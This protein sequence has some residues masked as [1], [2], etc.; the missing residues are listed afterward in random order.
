MVDLP[1][2]V[3]STIENDRSGFTAAVLLSNN[4]RTVRKIRELLPT[5]LRMVTLTSSS[6][7][8]ENLKESNIDVEL[9]E[10]SL[11]SQGLSVL[12]SLHDII[13]QGL[14][15]GRFKS[16]DR[17]LAMLGE[18]MDGVIYG[19]AASLGF[20]AYENIEYVLYYYELPSFNIALS[21]A[22]LLIFLSLIAA[23]SLLLKSPPLYNGKV[24]CI[25]APVEEV[26]V[27]PVFVDM[28]P[29][30]VGPQILLEAL[31]LSSATLS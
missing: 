11:S 5:K 20:A 3:A 29:V 15:E 26:I 28:L 17:I 9:L 31:T 2:M 14:G 6:K 18:P 10:D 16:N 7:V 12:N 23:R 30:I 8:Y 19:I 21:R 4:S 1:N 13:L 27:E 25:V 24:A 22:Y